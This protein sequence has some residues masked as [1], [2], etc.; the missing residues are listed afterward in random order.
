[1]KLTTAEIWLRNVNA[2]LAAKV[3]PGSREDEIAYDCYVTGKSAR[4]TAEQ[5]A[6]Y[7][8]ERT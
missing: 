7:R 2:I 1:M 4:Q 6:A 5:I 3:E 8:D